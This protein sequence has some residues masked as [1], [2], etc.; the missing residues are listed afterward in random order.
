LGGNEKKTVDMQN[1]FPFDYFRKVLLKKFIWYKQYCQQAE[2]RI[3]RSRKI[4]L[5]LK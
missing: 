3:S 5:F 2:V 4:Y 1:V